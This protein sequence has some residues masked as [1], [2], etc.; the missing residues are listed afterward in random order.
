MKVRK[1]EI[2]ILTVLLLITAFFCAKEELQKSALFSFLAVTEE[3]SEVIHFW[4]DEEGKYCVFL[5][6]YIKMNQ[7]QYKG[8]KNVWVG[9][10]LLKSG[11]FC[12]E[13][14][15][16]KNYELKDGGNISFFQ[17]K[18]IPAM[19]ID[20]ASGDMTYIH[21]EKGNKEAGAVRLYTDDGRLDYQGGIE[22]IQMRGNNILESDK[23][24]YSLKLAN[25]GKLLGMGKA[26]KWI[27]LSNSFD[28]SHIRNKIVFDFASNVEMPF[29]PES[30]WVDLYLNGEYAGLYLLCERNEV[31]PQRVAIAEKGSALISQE[32]E[33]RLENQN[34]PFIHTENGGS[35]R[36]HY[37][38][39]DDEELN[40]LWNRAERAIYSAGGIDAQ[41]GKH[42]TEYIDLD[43]WIKKYLI[44]EIFGNL[45][46]GR[47]SQFFYIDGND[48]EKKIYAGP[49]WDYD[50]A[51]GNPR[52]IGG[53]GLQV[54]YNMFYVNC[55]FEYW[56]SPWYNPLYQDRFFYE[57]MVKVYEQEFRPELEKLLNGGISE[58]FE[59]IR[60]AIVMNNRRW[61]SENIENQAEI[62]VT[63]LKKRMNFLDTVWIKEKD[64]VM[65]RADWMGRI[66]NLAVFPGDSM[67]TLP[68]VEQYEWYDSETDD[69][70]DRTQPID[71]SKN[72]Y[73]KRIN[74]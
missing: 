24:P 45:D 26:S 8:K 70:F 10:K 15:E 19:Y 66:L 11:D 22:S 21:K 30:R 34:L 57:E 73:L 61:P 55:P 20:T 17:S 2:Y 14:H 59:H 25:D 48:P 46:G 12:G 27:L 23:K 67:S 52:M 63:Y 50:M 68:S 56:G 5:P 13:L 44:E 42:W 33:H 3:G 1:I 6:G 54:P 9:D 38:M 32:L 64:Y 74:Q 29:T 31:H 41:T 39:M 35:L 72:I 49:V 60:P 16:N 51:L 7:L 58:C 47:V 43:S 40:Q 71:K 62:I 28:A 36:I 69:P 65:V 4:E 18:N 53:N 37:A